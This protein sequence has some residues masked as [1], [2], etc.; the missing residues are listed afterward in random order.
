MWEGLSLMEV[1]T[2]RTEGSALWER[3]S[4]QEGLRDVGGA[5]NVVWDLKLNNL[6]TS[7]VMAL[8]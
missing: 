6:G 4:L 8:S 2:G 5:E 3:L 7:I 1:L